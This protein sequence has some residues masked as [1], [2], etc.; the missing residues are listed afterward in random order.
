MHAPRWLLFPALLGFTFSGLEGTEERPV[1]L[2][3]WGLSSEAWLELKK[4]P[5]RDLA[6]VAYLRG[7]LDGAFFYGGTPEVNTQI[8]S[9][10]RSSHQTATQIINCIDTFF[11]KAINR[12]IPTSFPA[13]ICLVYGEPEPSGVDLTEL[14][15]TMLELL[16]SME[17][18]EDM[19]APKDK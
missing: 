19:T 16:E 5:D 13:L 10:A 15:R 1:G 4:V 9:A 6:R 7:L 12:F 3:G 2:W 17:A 11:E 8:K 18:R 14:R